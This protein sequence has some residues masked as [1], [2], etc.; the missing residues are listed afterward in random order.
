MKRKNTVGFDFYKFNFSTLYEL[1]G[2]PVVVP[3]GMARLLL[4]WFM[5]SSPTEVSVASKV[6]YVSCL[7]L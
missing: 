6:C 1:F 2:P 3:L 7:R 5:V 4:E